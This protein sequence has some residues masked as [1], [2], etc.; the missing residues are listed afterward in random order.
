MNVKD[1]VG[2]EKPSD[3]MRD[4]YFFKETK[5]PNKNGEGKRF[6]IRAAITDSKITSSRPSPARTKD[7]KI[8]LI[9]MDACVSI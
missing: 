1:C 7:G 8:L 6:E 4:F 3:P 5:T 2:D 9:S